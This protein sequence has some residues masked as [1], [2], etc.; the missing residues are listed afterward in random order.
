[1]R[2]ALA[3]CFLAAL[4]AAAQDSPLVKILTNHWTT[5]RTY[6]LAVAA[7]MP[8]EHYTFKPTPAQMTFG[9]QMLHIANANGYFFG[10]MTGVKPPAGP[11]KAAAANK[12]A[13][14]KALTESFDFAAAQMAAMKD[15]QLLEMVESGEGKMT[16]FE[17]VMLAFDHTAHHRAQT[18]VYLRLNGIVPTEYKF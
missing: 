10:K 5:A 11:D 1:M 7:Q 12:A 15:S 2:L 14:V 13:V 3:L 8:E 16:R 4:P 9:E 18:L 17:G 6:T